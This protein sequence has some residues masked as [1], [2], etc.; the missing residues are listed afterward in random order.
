MSKAAHIQ[1]RLVPF[2]LKK[3]HEDYYSHC[4]F[5]FSIR[6]SLGVHFHPVSA[7]L[8]NED[9]IVLAGFPWTESKGVVSVC[10]TL[11]CDVYGLPQL[12]SLA[13]LMSYNFRRKM[14]Q[15]NCRFNK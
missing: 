9:P 7:L 2:H 12:A 6:F 13:Y 11:K 14:M 10:F 1:Y 3:Y 15:S 8:F 4:P 5:K